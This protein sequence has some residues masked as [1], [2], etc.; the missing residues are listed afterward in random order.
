MAVINP[1]TVPL[2]SLYQPITDVL[3]ASEIVTDAYSSSNQTFDSLATVQWDALGTKFN[4]QGQNWV[5]QTPGNWAGGAKNDTSSR[6]SGGVQFNM[7]TL[8]GFVNTGDK[9]EIMVVSTGAFDMQVYVEYQGKMVKLKD[10]PLSSSLTSFVVRQIKFAATLNGA[11]GAVSR[12]GYKR[13]AFYVKL[14]GNANFVQL[15]VEAASLTYPTP[16]RHMFVIGPS[17]S[18]MEP[19]HN[20]NAGSDETYFGYGPQDALFEATGM[21]PWNAAEGGTGFFQNGDGVARTD[22]TASS[23]NGTRWGSTIRKAKIAA[24]FAAGLADPNVGISKPLFMLGHG[25]IN[26]GAL[27]GGTAPM[28]ARAKVVYAEAMALDSAGLMSMIH[29]GPEPYTAIAATPPGYTAGSAGDLNRLGQIAAVAETPRAY[30]VDAAVPTNPWWT[31][32]AANNTSL[33]DQQA[34]ITGADN[35][36]GNY[37]GFQQHGRRI[38]DAIG[39]I[40]IPIGRATRSA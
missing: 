25:S 24:G 5:Q 26:D 11:G 31:G 22:D 9:L 15:N 34:L 27:S 29:V 1:K 21:V 17:D 28:K 39:D 8:F 35:V 38:A 16:L 40:P 6:A 12:G 7:S 20:Q 14:A 13:R 4:L 36:H 3:P 37:R 18:Y 32:N 33:T 19:L 30:F 2:R 10:K 23:V